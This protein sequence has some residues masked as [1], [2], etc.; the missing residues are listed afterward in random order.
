MPRW[1]GSH[2]ERQ[3][4]TGADL[5]VETAS[6]PDRRLLFGGRLWQAEVEPWRLLARIWRNRGDAGEPQYV[7]GADGLTVEETVS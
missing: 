5:G 7:V 6:R 4:A 2:H 1:P 3:G